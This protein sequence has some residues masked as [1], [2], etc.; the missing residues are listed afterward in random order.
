MPSSPPPPIAEFQLRS[1]FALALEIR[2]FFAY[3]PGMVGA[4][5]NASWQ[6]ADGVA[7]HVPALS[8]TLASAPEGLSARRVERWLDLPAGA[9]Q[10]RHLY[11]LRLRGES[12]ASL[13][14]LRDDL[15][16]V[17]PGGREQPGSIVVT[18]SS[19]GNSLKKIRQ[20]VS[21]DGRLSNV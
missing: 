17:E 21:T 8:P 4:R 12:F 2:V 20:P 3:S 11:A 14:L 13:G 16:V 15:I 6:D 5:A 10:R 9:W 19:S 1:I 18:R 7:D